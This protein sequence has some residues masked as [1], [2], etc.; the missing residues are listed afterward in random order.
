MT[1]PISSLAGVPSASAPD[2][3]VSPVART[4]AATGDVSA[5][6]SLRAW[7]T[8]LV[9]GHHAVLAYHP[10]APALAKSMTDAPR[11][12]AAFPVVDTARFGGWALFVGSNENFFMALM[13]LLSG[14]FAWPALERKGAGGYLRQRARRLG[15]PFVV[16]AGVLAPLAYHASYVQMGGGGGGFLRTWLAPGM[17]SSGP[18]WFLWVLL[19]FDL[20]I[21]AL[22]H[23]APAAGGRLG[24]WAAGGG[25]SAGAFVALF[26][27]SSVGYVALEF[28]AGPAAWWSFGPFAV[29]TCRI[30]HYFVY[31][32]FGVG[33]GA[34]GLDRT[35]FAPGGAVARRWG[36]WS[37]LAAA[38]F[39][40]S[41]ASFL[42]AISLK[43]LPV[44]VHVAADLAYTFSSAASSFAALAIFL[45]FAR[46]RR[47]FFAA[48]TPCAY[49]MYL[50]HYPIASHLQL[51]M[52]GAPVGGFVKGL[53]VGVATV[54]LSWGVVA[55]LRRI[56]A[57]ARVI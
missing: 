16:L 14:L 45:R 29:Q 6:G 7:I 26:A 21:A 24:A 8:L 33:I 13:F 32:L 40:V 31:F 1:A 47:A 34:R 25:R 43:P 42:Y 54:G 44:G 35:V 55:M 4:E 11:L 38:A 36:A 46:E 39:A 5:I 28:T 10:Y 20:V 49:G 15:I 9:L 37:A 23:V 18:A 51:A 22:H 19:V 30:L 48:L 56:P 27:A 53:V 52:L 50:V 17:W 3:V 57:V 41:I 2:R 12:W